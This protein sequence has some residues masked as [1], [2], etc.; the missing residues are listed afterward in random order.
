MFLRDFKASKLREN[1]WPLTISSYKVSKAAINAYT[2]LMARKFENIL[3]NCVHPGYV[4]T[5]MTAR[6]GFVTPEEGAKGPVMAALLTDDQ[7]FGVYFNE[8]L[9]VAPFSSKGWQ[10]K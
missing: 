9:Q 3:V 1:G 6:T 7:P 10:E 2:R 4:I 8:I 5:D